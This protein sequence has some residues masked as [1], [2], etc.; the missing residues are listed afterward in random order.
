MPE[1]G[2]QDQPPEIAR[3]QPEPQIYRDVVLDVRDQ[4]VSR[5]EI[6]KP[7]RKYPT[8]P[9]GLLNLSIYLPFGSEPGKYHLTIYKSIDSATPLLKTTGTERIRQGLTTV[10]IK[11]DTRQMLPAPYVLQ[12]RP[13]GWVIGLHIQFSRRRG[14]EVRP[15][16]ATKADSIGTPLV[17]SSL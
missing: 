13:E 11:V 12:S 2:Q 6:P 8:I 14:S 1:P 9:R 5:G 10:Q 16:L 7:E 15:M 17:A 4:S 3:Q